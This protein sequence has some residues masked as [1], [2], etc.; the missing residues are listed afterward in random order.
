MVMRSSEATWLGTSREGKGTVRLGSGMFE[1]AYSWSARFEQAAGTN[2]EELIAAAHAGCFS[3]ALASGLARAG[4]KPERIHT[5]SQVHI[6]RVGEG[7]KITHIEL[8]T[9]AAIPGISAEAFQEQAAAAKVGCPVSQALASVP[10][11]LVAR[12]VA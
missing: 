1:G 4:F 3:M 9:E 10:I 11:T 6:E 5:V 8:V 7:W 12:L 2:P